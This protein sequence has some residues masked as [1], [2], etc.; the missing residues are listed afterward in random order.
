MAIHE[1]ATIDDG[2]EVHQDANIWQ[3]AHIRVGASIGA[4]SIIGRG[5]YVGSGVQVGEKC[6]I[7]NYALVYEP[8]KLATGVFIGPGVIFT[9]DKN[10][11]AVNPDLTLKSADDWQPVGVTCEE[12]A[13]VGAGAVCV[14]PVTIGAW[15]VVG[16]GAVVTRDVPPHA[17]VVGNPAKQ[18]GWVGHHGERLEKKETG[19]WV[20]PVS[21]DRYIENEEGEITHG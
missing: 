3:L 11:R 15:A 17:L 14:A 4:S 5:V 20:C 2:A 16:S 19:V 8:A 1:S 12:G 13:S 18:I 21:G 6:K 10:P 7:Q 9:N